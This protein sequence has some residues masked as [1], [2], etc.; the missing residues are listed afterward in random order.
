MNSSNS[1]WSTWRPPENYVPVPSA[2]DGITVYAP[3]KIEQRD[4]QPVTYLCPKCG[5]VTRYNVSAG[6]VACE[7]CSYTTQ[8]EAKTVGRRAADFEFTLETIHKAEQGWG[9]SKLEMH[10]DACGAD[11]VV[12]EKILAVTCPFCTSNRVNIRPAVSD[13]LQPLFLIP[14]EIQPAS[15][16]ERARL[17]LGSGWYHP[18][19]LSSDTVISQFTGI[20]L[21]FFTFDA[22][23]DARWK[24]EVGYE[25]QERYYDAGAKEWRSRTVIDWRWESGAVS[26]PVDDM[27]LPG[28]SHVSRV[29]LE[30]IYPFHLQSLK[31]YQPAFLAGWQAHGA[32]IPLTR[33][34]DE[35]K[36]VMREQGRQACQ[37]DIPTHHVRNFS[38]K[39]DFKNETWRYI[40]LP[41][42][43]ASY[44]FK[45]KVY[46]VMINGQ[47]GTISGQKPV[48]WWKVW[49]AILASLLPGLITGFIGLPLLIAGGIGLIPLFLGLVFL[50]AGIVF[51]VDLYRKAAASEA[52]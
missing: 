20:Y 10:C 16:V 13:Q 47:T 24:A 9:E 52:A 49:L 14:F 17:W 36:A 30:R 26:V 2:A 15:N 32:D 4:Q 22:G 40:L 21:P 19:E 6:G 8:I 33:A 31:E 51:S 1:D 3:L 23:I 48:D 41:V 29:I 46:Q 44:C 38:M 34:W 37:A 45:E 18:K 35:A 28:S 43:L 39:A 25:R 27:L 50:I 12:Q 11:M 7:H 42:Y 5:A